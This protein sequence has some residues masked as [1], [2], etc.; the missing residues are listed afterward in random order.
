MIAHTVE[1]IAYELEVFTVELAELSHLVLKS[2]E[3]RKRGRVPVG[4]FVLGETLLQPIH[5]LHDVVERLVETV[6]DRE[7]FR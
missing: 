7:R 4:V 6:G 2:F 1:L 3:L 5:L